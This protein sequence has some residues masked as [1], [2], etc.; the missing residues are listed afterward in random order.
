MSAD[1]KSAAGLRIDE[2]H[3]GYG[4][5]VVLHSV[6]LDL[7][8]G[9]TLAVL[10]RNGVGK[11]TLLA[12]IMGHT[13]LHRGTVEYGGENIA[14]FAP[15]RR[16][17]LGIGFVPQEREIFRSLSVE[18]NLLVAE[19]SPAGRT[20]RWTIARVYDFFPSLADRRH[21]GG[22]A[23]SGGEQ[24]MLSIGRA[25]MGNPSLLLMDEPLEGLAPVIVDTVLQGL[26][27][28]KREDDLALLLVEQHA[29][30][31]LEFAERALVLD[32]GRIVHQGASQELLSRPDQL[33][34]L[35]GVGGRAS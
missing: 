19:R 4:E 34:E 17:R 11:T 24:Q 23:L 12:T 35:M 9:G 2:L 26:E 3:A 16:A 8:P 22:N 14:G 15:Y 6:A 20:G 18:E 32:R 27:R 10:G 29:R 28:L 31:A 30:I 5:T 1:A 13:T 25:L 21:N 33:A 7:P